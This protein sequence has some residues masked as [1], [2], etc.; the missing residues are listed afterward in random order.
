[1]TQYGKA[2][3]WNDRYTRDPE[4][5][6]WYQ[7]Y[8]GLKPFMIK[9]LKLTDQI[10]MVGAGNS[11]LSEEMYND[12]FKAITNIDISPVVTEAMQQKY[13][14]LIGMTYKVMD[15]TNLSEIPTASFDAAIDKGTLDAILCGEGSVTNA[16]KAMAEIS[17]ILKPGGIFMII[18]YGDTA[19][20]YHYL[21]KPKYN[22]KLSTLTIEKPVV[23]GCSTDNEFHY[24]YVMT[25][26]S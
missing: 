23:A 11:R 22:W 4:P 3:Y 20:R 19:S 5:F 15:V 18:S 24:I 17:R 12:G 26:N 2:D 13:G 21:D 6:D 25:K 8:D 9:Y 1:M 14:G 10:L 7:R 16:D